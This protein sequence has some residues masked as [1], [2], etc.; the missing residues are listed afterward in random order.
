MAS[1]ILKLILS[2]QREQLVEGSVDLFLAMLGND[3][4]QMVRIAENIGSNL[5]AAVG[6]E[7]LREQ[8]RSVAGMLNSRAQ[9]LMAF[10]VRTRHGLGHPHH[11]TELSDIFK[12]PIAVSYLDDI[13]NNDVAKTYPK[14]DCLPVGFADEVIAK[15]K[16]GSKE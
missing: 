13:L 12:E 5:P 16:S 4:S 10:I 9:D 8:S 6:D 3:A 15:D 2:H 7:M 14:S 1:D 11:D